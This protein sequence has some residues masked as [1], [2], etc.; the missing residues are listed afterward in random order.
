MTVQDNSARKGR[1]AAA[2]ATVLAGMF[3][4]ALDRGYA[5]DN[6]RQSSETFEKA[7]RNMSTHA[8]VVFA[9][10]VNDVTGES[11][12]QCV[13]A[14]LLLG[15]IH[16]EYDLSYDAA[17]I[18]TAIKIALENPTREFHF[19]KQAA[20]DNVPLSGKETEPYLKNQL[21]RQLRLKQACDLVKG[22]N[23]VFLA[24]LTG[25]ASIDRTR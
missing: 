25:Q 18:E 6:F 15:A 12:T 1:Y 13:P 23:S 19:S 9:T 8:Y 2:I 22:G 21:L 24:D 10:I 14:P 3:F 11:H 20:I 4:F 7:I 5:E 16:R 17:S